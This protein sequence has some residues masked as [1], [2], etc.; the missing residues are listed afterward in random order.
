MIKNMYRTKILPLLFTILA[1]SA[2]CA[3]KPTKYETI[4]EKDKQEQV[5]EEESTKETLEKRLNPNNWFDRGKIPVTWPSLCLFSPVT[6]CILLSRS[7]EK[8]TSAA[9]IKK[10]SS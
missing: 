10:V 3:T 2:G 5:S 7:R 6:N 1:L 9:L 4:E 8:R